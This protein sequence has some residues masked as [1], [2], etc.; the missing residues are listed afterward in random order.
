MELGVLL[1]VLTR[2]TI[3]VTNTDD[4][5]P[6]SLRQAILQ[7][8]A[9]VGVLDTITFILPGSAPHVIQLATALPEVT[10]PVVIDASSLMAGT[11]RPQLELNA[12]GAP[13][14]LAVL[15]L[16]AGNCIVRSLSVTRGADVGIRI[17]TAGGNRLENVWVGVNASLA[18]GSG[19]TGHGV[20]IENVPSNAMDDLCVIGANGGDGVRVQG[21]AATNNQ[22]NAWIGSE[23][24]SFSARG[25]GG[26]GI[27]FDQTGSNAVLSAA[28]CDNGLGGIGAGGGADSLILGGAVGVVIGTQ[29]ALPLGNHGPGIFIASGTSHQ[30]FGGRVA[31]NSQGIVV[32][33]GAIG[34]RIESM[35][36]YGNGGPE[37]DLN[38]DGRTPN[39]PGDADLG[40]NNLQNHPVVTNVVFTSGFGSASGMAEVSVRFDGLPSTAY[41]IQVLPA[42]GSSSDDP[43]VSL[44][45]GTFYDVTTDA[46]GV[47]VH[48]LSVFMFDG[49]TQVTALATDPAGNTSE[50]APGFML[51][52]LS[53]D[54]SVCGATGLEALLLLLLLRRRR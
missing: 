17:R 16:S 45:S 11:G 37:I 14:P 12:A 27:Y 43:Q 49:A 9:S 47:S 21:P 40:G 24:V 22:V 53:A 32:T 29:L 18:T 23:R 52:H 39:D 2:I 41:R 42:T 25:N 36:L 19:N 6:G 8:N 51:S 33:N 15:T 28:I 5:G 10:D 20:V 7:S 38:Q 31:H 13:G 26:W 34:V 35:A 50:L 48:T 1:A 44:P 30:I 4:A 3:D 54:S 46:S